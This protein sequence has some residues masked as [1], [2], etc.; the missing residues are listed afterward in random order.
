MQAV[1]IARG[2][3]WCDGVG[4]EKSSKISVGLSLNHASIKPS[5]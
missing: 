1:A 3:V 4:K 2:V 5:I